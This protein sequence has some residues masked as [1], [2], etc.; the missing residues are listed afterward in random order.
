L[1]GCDDADQE[2]I[3][4]AICQ[5]EDDYNACMG[6]QAESPKKEAI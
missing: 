2:C 4:D 6:I 1:A 3:A 5:E